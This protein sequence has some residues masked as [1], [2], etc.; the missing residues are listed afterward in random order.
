MLIATVLQRY[1]EDRKV[2]DS[3][4]SGKWT[5][6]LVNIIELPIYICRKCIRCSLVG[7]CSPLINSP[8]LYVIGHPLITYADVRAFGIPPFA[9][10]T[11]WDCIVGLTLPPGCVRN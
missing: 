5:R 3:D 8:W 4:L 7:K 10:N 9:C 1:A 6:G 2:C 11:Q